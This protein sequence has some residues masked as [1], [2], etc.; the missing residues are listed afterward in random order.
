[1]LTRVNVT[2]MHYLP[3]IQSV[4]QD[5][6]DCSSAN[7]LAPIGSTVSIGAALAADAFFLKLSG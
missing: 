5:G 7:W 3:D 1:M 2:A 4:L 6:V